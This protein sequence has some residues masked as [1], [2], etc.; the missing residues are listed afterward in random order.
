MKSGLR[1]K[2]SRFKAQ[3]VSL[4]GRPGGFFVQ[5]QYMGSLKPVSAAYPEV[6]RLCENAPFQDFLANMASHLPAFAQFG[7][8]PLDPRLGCGMFPLRD[9]AAAYT[10]VREFKPKRIIEIGSGDST[11]FL[12]K[13]AEGAEITCIDPAPRREIRSLPVRLMERV[14]DENDAELCAELEANDILFIDSS[15]VAFPGTDVD[16]EFNRMFP[17]LKAGVIVHVHDIF[18]PFD[19]PAHWRGRNWNEQNALVGWLFGAFDIIYPGHYVLRRHTDLMDEALASF[20]PLQRKS[21]G[22]MWLRKC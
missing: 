1:E 9:G 20:A 22:S 15:H 7:E 21:A 18:L 5:Y 3:A 14:L 13:A 2:F 16:I 12:A 6:E 8:S 11:Y 4:A 19:Y 17:R 10:A